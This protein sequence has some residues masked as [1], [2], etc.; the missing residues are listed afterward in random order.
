MRG[1][2]CYDFGMSGDFETVSDAGPP[3]EIN[4]PRNRDF[5][6][7]MT[8]QDSSVSYLFEKAFV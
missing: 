2:S 1:R 8:R 7:A 5:I 4:F 3:D 6:L